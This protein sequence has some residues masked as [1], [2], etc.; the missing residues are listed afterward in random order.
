MPSA[1]PTLPDD[2][3]VELV[4]LAEESNAALLRGDVRRYRALSPTS[5]DFTLMSPFGGV[6]SRGTNL[7]DENWAAIGRFFR[8]GRLKLELVE[9]YRSA[10]LVVLAGIERAH[11]EVGE[12][13]AQDWSLRVT[14]VYRR[15]AAGWSLVH[16][17]ADPL[18]PG[19][20]LQQAAALARG[21]PAG[22][23]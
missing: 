16:R 10:D 2:E 21:E 19:I 5:S 11:V 13:P 9:S 1:S 12:L 17:H 7:N 18:A 22:A 6:P 23:I 3:L 15:E 20:S 14:L 8:N 4:R